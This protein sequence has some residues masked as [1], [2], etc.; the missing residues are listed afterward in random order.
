VRGRVISWSLLFFLVFECLVECGMEKTLK[1][2]IEYVVKWLWWWYSTSRCSGAIEWWSGSG[3]EDTW[4]RGRV[5][6]SS[7]GQ[8]VEVNILDQRVEWWVEV[9]K[10]PT[11]PGGRVVCWGLEASTR[12]GGRVVWYDQVRFFQL[13]RQQL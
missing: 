4:P 10:S 12:P 11:R 5:M 1:L 13:A 7:D 2:A 3:G 8:V 9:V 6:W